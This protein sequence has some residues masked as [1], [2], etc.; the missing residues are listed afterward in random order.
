MFPRYYCPMY[1][2]LLL[3]HL[4]QLLPRLVEDEGVDG[5]GGEQGD[6]HVEQHHAA[7][8]PELGG[9][10]ERGKNK[11]GCAKGPRRKVEEESVAGSKWGVDL[12]KENSKQCFP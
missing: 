2:T 12:K 5:H 6:G 10:E 1:Y 3:P 8:V 7:H 11:I 4:V 9:E